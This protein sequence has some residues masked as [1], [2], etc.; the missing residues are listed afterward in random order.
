MSNGVTPGVPD[1]LNHY[2]ILIDRL[3]HEGK[4][5]WVRFNVFF[6][7]ISAIFAGYVKL[8]L[9]GALQTQSIE[10]LSFCSTDNL[11]LIYCILGFI[12]SLSWFFANLDGRY[13]QLCLQVI[14]K[15]FEDK[16]KNYFQG[17]GLGIDTVSR[18]YSGP[19]LDVIDIAVELSAISCSLW[20]A[21]IIC[22][23]ANSLCVALLAAIISLILL[24]LI[25]W[26][27]TPKKKVD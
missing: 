2:S 7:I 17:M 1:I 27:R 3:K 12:V 9:L 21:L 16:N 24:L 13:W 20:L 22:Q 4:L 10:N 19:G 11:H 25:M 18:Y 14:I 15:S 5:I 23:I 8:F 6:F 26:R